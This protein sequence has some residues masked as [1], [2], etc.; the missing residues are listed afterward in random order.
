MLRIARRPQLTLRSR[1][2]APHPPHAPLTTH[3]HVSAG[4][5][6]APLALPTPPAPPAPPVTPEEFT[7]LLCKICPDQRL[8][9]RLGLAISGG[10]DS[11]ALA[12]LTSQLLTAPDP[13]PTVHAFIVDHLT[14]PASTSDAHSAAAFLSSR[15]NFTAHVLPLKPPHPSLPPL[16]L[17]PKNSFETVARQYRWQLLSRHCLELHISHLLLAHHIDDQAETVVM[18]I[19]NGTGY[20]GIAGMRAI[21]KPP[22]SK[23][24]RGAVGRLSIL[25]PFLVRGGP[26]ANGGRDGEGR[27]G[28]GKERLIATCRAEGIPWWEDPTNKDTSLTRRNAIRHLL[29]GGAAPAPGPAPP[30]RPHLLPKALSR[31]SLVN[32]AW[33]INS[34]VFLEDTNVSMKLE[35]L[36]GANVSI[37]SFSGTARLTLPRLPP[38]DMARDIPAL[39][40]ALQKLADLLTPANRPDAGSLRNQA[41][42]AVF[43]PSALPSAPRAF[44]AGGILWTPEGL[45][46]DTDRVKWVLSRQPRYRTV[47]DPAAGGGEMHL[48]N[49][50]G[51][52][53]Q[54]RL[55]DGRFYFRR[56]WD[57]KGIQT[58]TQTHTDTGTGTNIK[59]PLSLPSP[60]EEHRDINIPPLKIRFLNPEEMAATRKSFSQ[61]DPTSTTITTVT[62]T[63]TTAAATET[64][65]ETTTTTRETTIETTSQP[66]YSLSALLQS[67]SKRNINSTLT[68]LTPKEANLLLS[69][70]LKKV[71][72]YARF[73]IPVAVAEAPSSSAAPADYFTTGDIVGF[74][75]LGLWK[76]GVFAETSSPTATTT[77]PP[78]ITI[79]TTTT[80]QLPSTPTLTTPP[81]TRTQPPSYPVTGVVECVMR[82][83]GEYTGEDRPSAG[84]GLGWD[85]KWVSGRHAA[86]NQNDFET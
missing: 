12:H 19:I 21:A 27:I 45:C 79:T 30:R 73:T 85:V 49:V 10:V 83:C 60:Q 66:Q 29:G 38:E 80:S 51:E 41:V 33:K 76:R 28:I 24:V 35:S 36:G 64:T 55:F 57:E 47:P 69:N 77:T 53:Q 20:A 74:P 18:R 78:R 48:S 34:R 3:V 4:T 7:H 2:A 23:G 42:P 71:P 82:G 44:T 50:P 15:Y 46:N 14:R 11:M 13:A 65:T 61:V 6:P 39:S 54:W 40:R 31:F 43:F 5:T 52:E 16:H 72:G 62:T 37:C 81:T 58:Q 56:R 59:T 25:R 9:S 17:C 8:P 70:A 68:H 86:Y 67:H 22:E 32:F 26:P 84:L 63:T 75:T 1:T